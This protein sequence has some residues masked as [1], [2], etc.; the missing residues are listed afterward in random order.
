LDGLRGEEEAF[1]GILVKGPVE[2]LVA[3]VVGGVGG[4][5]EE[6]DDAV[7]GVQLGERVGVE[8]EELLELDVFYAEVV[9]QVGEDA[10]ELDL[11]ASPCRVL[12]PAFCMLSPFRTGVRP[13]RGSYVPRRTRL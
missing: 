5:L 10:L 4:E 8:R 2:G 3:G 12:P 1:R 11:S 7:D 13:C 9:E 6:E